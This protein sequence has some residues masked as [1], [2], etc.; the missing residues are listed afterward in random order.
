MEKKK[1]LLLIP[2]FIM[3]PALAGLSSAEAQQNGGK[4]ERVVSNQ[5]LT[6]VLKQLEEKFS[7]S[8]V[9]N[10]DELKSYKVNAKINATTAEEAIKQAL[11]GL[12]V[13]YTVKGKTI[14]IKSTVKTRRDPT[15]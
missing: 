6:A 4:Y 15:R 11:T 9:F 12:P 2:C 7:Q 5:P 1:L 10:Y 8:I 3:L 14:T 13:T